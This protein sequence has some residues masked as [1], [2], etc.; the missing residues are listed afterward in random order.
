MPGGVA[1]LRS[2]LWTMIHPQIIVAR[3]FGRVT[4]QVTDRTVISNDA[5][6]ALYVPLPANTVRDYLDATWMSAHLSAHH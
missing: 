6:R 3:L 5:R 2:A 1:G 4:A